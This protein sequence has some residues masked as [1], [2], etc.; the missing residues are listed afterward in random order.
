MNAIKKVC[1]MVFYGGPPAAT[2]FPICRNSCLSLESLWPQ[3]WNFCTIVS[4]L[5]FSIKDN[6]LI[7]IRYQVHLASTT[8]QFHEKVKTS[9]M[10]TTKL[11]IEKRTKQKQRSKARSN[12]QRH[13]LLPWQQIDF[14]KI[15]H[16]RRVKE[17]KD[18]QVSLLD[19]VKNWIM[20]F[21]SERGTVQIH[22]MPSIR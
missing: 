17:S 21:H 3:S 20:S 16:K 13:Q 14:E 4:L 9:R 6:I 11:F 8:T 22:A 19:P 15:L 5:Y 18:T 2:P 12:Q 7:L 1:E 10:N